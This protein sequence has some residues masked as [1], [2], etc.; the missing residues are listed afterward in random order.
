MWYAQAAFFLIA[1]AFWLLAPTHAFLQISSLAHPKNIVAIA[2]IRLIGPFAVA[3]GFLTML[4]QTSSR[5]GMYAQFAR[6]FAF[7]LIPWCAVVVYI[8]RGQRQDTWAPSLY[9]F[10]AV[11][12]TFML[13]NAGV[14][15]SS[16]S[17]QV[18]AKGYAT[19]A[20]RRLWAFWGLQAVL[21][22]AMGAVLMFRP[23]DVVRHVTSPGSNAFRDSFTVAQFRMISPYP[24]SVAFFTIYGMVQTV[25]VEIWTGLCRIFAALFWLLAVASLLTYDPA[26]FREWL[27][28]AA[29]LFTIL[30]SA[31][32]WMARHARRDALEEARRDYVKWTPLDLPAGVPMWIQSF[33][34]KRRASHL[35]GVGAQGTFTVVPDPRFPP[36][37]FFEAGRELPIQ[38]RFANLTHEDD[39]ALDVRGAA[40]KLLS[41]EGRSLYDTVLNTGSFCPASNVLEFSK[42]VVSKFLPTFLVKMALQRDSTAREGGVAGLR[43]APTSYAALHYYGQIVRG[44]I[45][46]DRHMH[47]VRYRLLGDPGPESGLPDA[48][49]CSHV[50]L[51]GRRPNDLRPTTYLRAEL[52][53]RLRRGPVELLFQAQFHRAVSG[54]SLAWYNA[55]VDWDEEDHPWHDVGRIV[56]DRALPDPETEKLVFNPGNQ[57]RSLYTPISDGFLDYRSLGDSEVMVMK[58]L[59]AMRTWLYDWFG[60]PRLDAGRES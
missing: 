39:A 4:G 31:N 2:G 36:N 45:D 6:L 23:E 27:L 35:F 7:F 19:T 41:K 14:A 9:A 44:W 11:G 54:E 17:P 49:D 15:F 37:E 50:W 55:G 43:R 57:P 28:V 58:R 13:L 32:A 10:L 1:G 8:V 3:H 16:R 21:M 48:S 30:G 18:T 38:M 52:V 24:F 56:L 33:F 22:L 12:S 42:F 20:P 34:T 5:R 40:I 47:L 59:Q 29:V 60:L 25:W 46:T 53:E 51:R 26:R